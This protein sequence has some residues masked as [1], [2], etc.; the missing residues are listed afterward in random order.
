MIVQNNIFT[1]EAV[2]TRRKIFI[3]NQPTKI[4]FS[5]EREVL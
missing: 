1:A 5:P 4:E 2:E 3:F